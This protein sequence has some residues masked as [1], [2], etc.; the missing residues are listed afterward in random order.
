MKT[1]PYLEQIKRLKEKADGY[2]IPEKWAEKIPEQ[3]LPE[4]RIVKMPL[5]EIHGRKIDDLSYTHP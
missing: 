5:N 1:N 3:H 4:I 2:L